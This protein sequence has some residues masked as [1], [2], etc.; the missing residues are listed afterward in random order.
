M[1][2]LRGPNILPLIQLD[3]RPMKTD[4]GRKMRPEFTVIDW[5]ERGSASGGLLDKSAPQIEDKFSDSTKAGKPI[6]PVSTEEEL[7][8]KIP[9]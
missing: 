1:R 3:S 8:D 2:E 9:W 7:N 6:K 4:F 5:R